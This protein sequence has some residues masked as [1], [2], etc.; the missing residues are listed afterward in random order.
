MTRLTD[1]PNIGTVLAKKLE[2]VGIDSREKL[3]EIGSKDALARIATIEDNDV[4][5][6]MLYALEGG[7]QGIRWHGLSK[8]EKME[9]KEYFHILTKLS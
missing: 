3:I 9:L 1:T 2:S 4:C 5:I 6:N 8:D 7:I